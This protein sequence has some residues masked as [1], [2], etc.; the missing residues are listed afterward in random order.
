VFEG[1]TLYITGAGVSA[2][3]GIPTFRG[4]SLTW[5]GDYYEAKDAIDH[6]WLFKNAF[7]QSY[8][9]VPLTYLPNWSN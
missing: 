6:N 2:E 1:N 3:S 7:D 8:Y 9:Y 5:Q 4:G